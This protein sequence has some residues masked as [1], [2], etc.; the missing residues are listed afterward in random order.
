[1]WLPAKISQIIWRQ[2]DKSG[3]EQSQGLRQLRNKILGER[4]KILEGQ[5]LV[6]ERVQSH[7]C[8]GQRWS[9]MVN[10]RL[11]RVHLFRAWGFLVGT[12]VSSAPKFIIAVFILSSYFLSLTAFLISSSEPEFPQQKMWHMQ[13]CT[14]THAIKKLRQLGIA[15]IT[16]V[17]NCP[18][19]N[20]WKIGA[21]YRGKY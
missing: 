9:T 18:S 16:P 17:T 10:L 20:F 14:H 5:S 7:L 19:R 11:K 8:T 6:V 21:K 1:M 15:D 3:Q 2:R 4:N 13:T 12:R